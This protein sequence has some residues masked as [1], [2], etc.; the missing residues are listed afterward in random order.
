M[1]IEK[2]YFFLNCIDIFD[3]KRGM[4]YKN[5]QV[6]FVRPIRNKYKLANAHSKRSK[7]NSYEQFVRHFRDKHEIVRI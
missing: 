7:C 6:L 1:K 4:V 2:I 5:L 3:S